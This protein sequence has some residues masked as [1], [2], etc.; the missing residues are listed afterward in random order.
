MTKSE[1]E[2]TIKA[3]LVAA[4][5]PMP[6]YVEKFEIKG[7]DGKWYRGGL[8]LGV[9][10]VGERRVVGWVMRMRDGVTVGNVYPTKEAAE[11]SHVAREDRNEAEFRAKLEASSAK[12]L[13]EQ[14][15]YWL[16]K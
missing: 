11:A 10:S 14:A 6:E 16:K 1:W 7:S 5:K 9:T 15:A 8:P 2:D 3:I 12:R 13:E 4:R